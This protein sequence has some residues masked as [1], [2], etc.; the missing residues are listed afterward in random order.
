LEKNLK[1]FQND[2]RNGYL[3]HGAISASFAK[4]YE[5]EMLSVAFPVGKE[6][7]PNMNLIIHQSEPEIKNRPK[8]VNDA[9]PP[10]RPRKTGDAENIDKQQNH[11]KEPSYGHATY[12]EEI[13]S[14]VESGENLQVGKAEQ[15]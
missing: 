13:T 9:G 2:A 6:Q 10:E 3:T 14:D 5:K 15:K 12:G 8:Q 7:V 1:F 11:I 4:T